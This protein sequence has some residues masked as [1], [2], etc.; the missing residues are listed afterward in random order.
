MNTQIKIYIAAAIT[1][2]FTITLVIYT[3]SSHQIAQLESAVAAAKTEADKKEQ[4][5]AA[6]EIEAAEYKRKIDYLETKLTEITQ[7]SRKQDEELQTLNNTSRNARSDVDRSRRT[8]SI[9]TT[10]AELCQKLAELG[11]ACE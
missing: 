3:W 1:V 11:H 9:T 10:A 8:R 2:I 4:T 7:L 6:K 5:A